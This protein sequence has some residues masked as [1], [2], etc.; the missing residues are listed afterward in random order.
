MKILVVGSGGR[1]HAMVWKLKKSLR[2]TEIFCTGKNA[3]IGE[4][5]TLVDIDSNDIP[6]LVEFAKKNGIDLT[7]VGPEAP[8]CNGIVDAFEKEGLAI[9]GPRRNAAILE[10]SKIFMKEFA[11][12]HNIPT[13]P[14]K[15]FSDSGKAMHHVAG[16]NK[17]PVVIKADGLAAGKGVFICRNRQEANLAINEIMTSKKF[18]D[19]GDNIIIEDCLVGEEASIIGMVDISGNIFLLPASQDHKRRD[20]GDKGPNTGGMGAYSPAPVITPELEE[21]ILDTI[22]YPAVRGMEEEGR[23]YVGFLYAGVMIVD[24]KPFLL[25]FNCR[26]GDP[27]AQAVLCGFYAGLIKLCA[28]AVCGDLD[29]A[30]KSSGMERPTVCVVMASKGYPGEYE[31]GFEILGIKEAEATGAKV[32]HAGTVM[33]DGKVFSAGGRVLGIT[34]SGKTI[35][36]AKE[37]AYR[38]A[39]K[40][41]CKNEKGEDMLFYRSDIADR[42]I[43]RKEE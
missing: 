2:A 36:E 23:P 37:N 15:I 20:N 22:M 1:E 12:R 24:G 29:I 3:G 18:G 6:A 43:K 17:F 7:I 16:K 40:I 10:G 30:K 14:F 33:K 27:E 21:E 5:A 19:A 41:I 11:Q 13:A 8:L 32:F 9:F 26:L 4:I 34:A 28:M 35:K 39:A 38:A 25:E 31:K 42:A